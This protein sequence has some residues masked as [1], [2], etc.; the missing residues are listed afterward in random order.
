ML[1]A[2]SSM[3]VL[4]PSPCN[5]IV[6]TRIMPFVV[7]RTHYCWESNAYSATIFGAGGLSFGRCG[8]GEGCLHDA[9]VSGPLNGIS[10]ILRHRLTG[11]PAY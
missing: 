4:R 3:A 9:R 11:T 5:A 1:S 2:G 10:N 8:Q 7:S 6:S